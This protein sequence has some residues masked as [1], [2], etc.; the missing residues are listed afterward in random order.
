MSVVLPEKCTPQGLGQ[1]TKLSLP[2]VSTRSALQITTVAPGVTV[3]KSCF[4]EAQTRT[5]KILRKNDTLLV[6]MCLDGELCLSC[7]KEVSE[8]KIDPGSCW[9]LHPSEQG[10]ERSVP[11]GRKTSSIV[12]TIRLDEVSATIHAATEA[13]TNSGET[14]SEVGSVP[15]AIFDLEKLFD[16]PLVGSE[17]LQIEGKCLAVIADVFASFGSVSSSDLHARVV[18]FLAP[19]IDQRVTL[20][21]VARHVGVNRTQLN[22]ALRA[23]SGQSVFE[24]LRAIR[25]KKAR[26]LRKQGVP[27]Q[28]V[29]DLTGFSSASHLCRAMKDWS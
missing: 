1:P 3:T 2:G 18:A 5:D 29:A 6:V 10:V 22:I 14:F 24:I 16:K 25:V 17:L 21:Q 13:F 11:A 19:R 12:V 7:L 23:H 28:Q 15:N 26:Q 27:T 8:V 20:D 9:L 4:L